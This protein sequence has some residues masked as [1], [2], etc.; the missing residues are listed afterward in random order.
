MKPYYMC[1]NFFG[2]YWLIKRRRRFWF[3]KT[4]DKVPILDRRISTE[5]ARELCSNLNFLYPL[6]LNG[7]KEAEYRHNL[8]K[9]KK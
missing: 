6:E 7:F 9:G 4:V 2:D 8:N 5:E 1:A 3:D